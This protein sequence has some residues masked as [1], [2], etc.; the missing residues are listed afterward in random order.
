M[1]LYLLIRND[2]RLSNLDEATLLVTVMMVAYFVP[3]YPM[4]RLADRASRKQLLAWGLL[5]NGVGFLCLGLSENY[6]WA[7]VSVVICGVGGSCF[8]PAATA[9]IAGLYPEKPGRALGFLGIGASVGFFIGP[10]YSGWRGYASG[11]RAPVL[12]LGVAGIVM[13]ILFWK[14][15]EEGHRAEV[16][17][18]TPR[19]SLFANRRI[20]WMFL[21]MA[22]GFSLRD[23][24]GAGNATL[25]SLYLQKA[26]GDTVEY[27]GRALSFVFLAS[28]IS[29]PIFGHFSDRY[30]LRSAAVL[31]ILSGISQAALPHLSHGMFSVGLM[32]F[33]FFLMATFPVVEAALMQAVS[34][35]IR[36]SFFGLFITIGG[37][38][39]NGSHW[40]MGRWVESLGELNKVPSNYI[41]L[42]TT[43]G[44]GV[45]LSVVA[46]PCLKALTEA[47]QLARATAVL[48]PPQSPNPVASDLAKKLH[49]KL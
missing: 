26:H 10:L 9:L 1:P 21:L 18:H 5:I 29:N 14:F 8:H 41:P 11:W 16:M 40:L 4:G 19:E 45:A 23:F 30:R 15:A 6:A 27:A 25:S 39:G 17:S 49:D 22:L 32:T 43:L 20:L 34:P 37:L 24:G 47:K 12:E 38:L 31:L 3:S 44:V 13:A 48:E 35:A 7:I 42:F 36:A 2:L 46:L 33:G 28:A